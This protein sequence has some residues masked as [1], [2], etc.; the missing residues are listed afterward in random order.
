MQAV[1]EIPVEEDAISRCEQIIAPTESK[2][3]S[4]RESLLFRLK[5][6]M[7]LAPRDV[8]QSCARLNRELVAM[9]KALECAAEHMKRMGPPGP[10]HLLDAPDDISNQ[11]DY[12]IEFLIERAEDVRS[13][14]AL[15]DPRRSRGRPHDELKEWCAEY[16]YTLI[17]E[18]GAKRPTLTGAN[19]NGD[20]GAFFNLAS[21]LYEIATGVEADIDWY[22][23][24]AKDRRKPE[25]ARNAGKARVRK[26]KC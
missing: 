23:R 5:C 9:A 6:F 4:C 16:A 20:S 25:E 2:R 14:V 17:S 3:V 26:E 24:L 1:D 8:P 11:W 21:A 15:F 13:T 22:C 19:R 12:V 10:L 7:Y 18:F